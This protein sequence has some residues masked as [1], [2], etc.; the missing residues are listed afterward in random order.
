M[1]E[2]PNG[3]SRRDFVKVSAG[4]SLISRLFAASGFNEINLGIQK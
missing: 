4:Y 2:N 1:S 3:V